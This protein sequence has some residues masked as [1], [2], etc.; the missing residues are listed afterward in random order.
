MPP[1]I[2][3]TRSIIGARIVPDAAVPAAD[4]VT[5]GLRRGRRTAL[6]RAGRPSY[7]G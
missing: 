1:G 3:R 7:R 5:A 4:T 6:T 2:A